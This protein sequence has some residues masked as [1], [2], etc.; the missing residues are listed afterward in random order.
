MISQ[1]KAKVLDFLF[2]PFCVACFQA[3]D[4][5]CA[6]CREGVQ[7]LTEQI[8]P[9]CLELIPPA[10]LNEGGVHSECDGKL[11]FAKAWALGY[12][13]DPKL[14][15][16][17]TAL[18]FNGTFSLLDS[19][20]SLVKNNLPVNLPADAV[21]VPMPLSSK[22]HKERGFNQAELLA[23]IFSEACSLKVMECLARIGHRDPQSSVEHDLLARQANIKNCFA[24]KGE[25]P[26][27]IILVDDV[28][29][30]G[31]TAAE[32]ARVL[33]EAGA[34]KV[35]VLALAIGA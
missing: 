12:Y 10:P 13:H 26:K 34:E 7:K 18:K 15:R 28:I 5:W 22:R 35:S 29:T 14:R 31:A 24:V 23:S 19:L 1:L 27:N 20:K 25:I 4:W 11:P 16:A 32:A 6:D 2:P 3:G 8:C 30:T 17:I 21:L 9:K 33:L